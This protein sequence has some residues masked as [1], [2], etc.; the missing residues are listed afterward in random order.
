MALNVTDINTA[1]IALLARPA[2]GSA[3]PWAS[4]YPSKQN[5]IKDVFLIRD[6]GDTTTASEFIERAYQLELGR[7]ADQEGLTYWLSRY[8][9]VGQEGFINE[10]L[11]AI[12]NVGK[13]EPSNTDYLSFK[14]NSEAF[15]NSLYNNLLGRDGEPAGLEYWTNLMLNGTTKP[16]IVDSFINAILASD[17]NNVDHQNFIA[18]LSA[19]DEFSSK[20][21]DF[22]PTL[23]ADERAQ[24]AEEI[25]LLIPNTDLNTDPELTTV[26]INNI[27][28]EYQDETL[29]KF[30]TNI[31]TLKAYPNN[32]T[33]FDGSID[34][35]GKTST[36]QKG[37]SV[38]GG[39]Y[40]D[41]LKVNVQ[42]NKTHDYFDFNQSMQASVS[43]V[44]NLVIN[45][46][47]ANVT[48]DL[49]DGNYSHKVNING[50]NTATVSVN[51]ETDYL[52]VKNA[53]EAYVTVNDDLK[54]YEGSKGKDTFIQ[55][56]GDI[57]NVNLND[58]NDEFVI[59][60]TIRS[61]ANIDL[62]KG[63]DI[64]DLSKANLT[65]IATNNRF[66]IDGNDGYDTLYLGSIDA[67][68]VTAIKNIEQIYSDGATLSTNT[69][70]GLQANLDGALNINAKDGFDLSSLKTQSGASINIDIKANNLTA[71]LSQ[72]DGIKENINIDESYNNVSIT[73]FKQG[74]DTLTFK[75]ASASAQIFDN[76][77]G[78]N[79]STV[80]GVAKYISDKSVELGDY[81]NTLVFNDE[82]NTYVWQANGNSGQ[83]AT[84]SKKATLLDT[85]ITVDD[86]NDVKLVDAVDGG[87]YILKTSEDIS[88][89]SQVLKIS[90]TKAPKLPPPKNDET[91]LIVLTGTKAK[92][93]L[94]HKSQ[95]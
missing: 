32:S 56:S 83:K 30:T 85:T 50:T 75:N 44:E 66:N 54:N 89:I 61:Q 42:T 81:I 49:N 46:L 31:D 91:E 92:Y 95:I 33:T 35:V 38:L 25:S 76:V 43:G 12:I 48:L 15:V 11:S 57:N 87:D 71:I 45:T 53:N 36:I 26:R 34:L 37:D 6:F 1:Y 16:V 62:G 90:K 21:S 58:G 28:G 73:N 63:D 9:D 72:D 77:S 84:L 17:P 68:K 78:Y 80:D 70:D 8:N 79:I 64:A 52:D 51:Q 65:N 19:A 10:F 13:V 47:N 4:S 60:G 39:D 2:E 41:T 20:F 18:K 55:A 22:K 67:S 24:G 40:N 94:R 27:V 86:I 23:N 69:V 5:L 29:V 59:N 82:Q 74:Q 3:L 7:S 14:Y 88:T 93:L